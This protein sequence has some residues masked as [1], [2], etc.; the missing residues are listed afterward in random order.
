MIAIEILAW[1]L[2]GLAVIKMIVILI[3]PKSW[4]NFARG[5]LS[6]KWLAQV[7]SLILLVV[8]F[9]YLTA[10][11][12]TVIQILAVTVFVALLFV[13]ALAGDIEFFLKKYDK[14]I[15]NGTLWKTYWLYTLI[16]IVLIILGIK[17]LIM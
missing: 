5:L 11:G 13:M 16:W 8:V 7:V 14:L 1:I 6:N 2:I 15:K 12:V 9:Y 17:E 10:A 3:S 4:L